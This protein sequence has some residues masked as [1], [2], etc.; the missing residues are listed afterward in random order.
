MEDTLENVLEG[1]KKLS[2]VLP[3]GKQNIMIDIDGTVCEDVPNEEPERM[4]TAEPYEDSRETI[5]KWFAEGHIITFFTSR[6][7]AD[8][9]TI[10]EEWLKKHG[11]HYHFLLMDKPRGGNYHW[12]DNHMV[13]ASRFKTNWKDLTEE[14]DDANRLT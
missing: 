14:I 5:N 12:I 13:R 8:H 9:K 10:T 6:A 3:T 11:F 2:P 1:G 4:V 7:S